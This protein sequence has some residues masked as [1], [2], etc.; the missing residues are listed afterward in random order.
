MG[1]CLTPLTLKPDA[2][3]VA[4]GGMHTRPLKPT[5]FGCVGGRY[6]GLSGSNITAFLILKSDFCGT[7][8]TR[9]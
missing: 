2:E 6:R 9:G 3:W 8:K 5:D 1:F 4:A 7:L